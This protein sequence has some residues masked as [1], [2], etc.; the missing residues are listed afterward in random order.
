MERSHANI[1]QTRNFKR[2]IR[3]FS[4]VS[5]FVLSTVIELVVKADKRIKWPLPSLFILFFPLKLFFKSKSYLFRKTTFHSKESIK[6][7]VFFFSK[8]KW[9]P[10]GVGHWTSRF[11]YSFNISICLPI[12]C[13]FSLFN[14]FNCYVL[15]QI[16]SRETHESKTRN[17]IKK[18]FKP[19]VI[20][21]KRQST[22]GMHIIY[23]CTFSHFLW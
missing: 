20:M 16:I 2:S 18:N 13:N 1:Y 10:T 7:I 6:W 4:F 23:N 11:N 19:K 12:K 22:V 17:L 15:F 8:L 9:W 21:Y 14:Y 3:C 5:R